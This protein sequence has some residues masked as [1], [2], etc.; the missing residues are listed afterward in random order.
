MF[1][2]ENDEKNGISIENPLLSP[3]ENASDI[4]INSLLSDNQKDELKLIPQSYSDVLSD[5]PGTTSVIEHDVM[6]KSEVPVTKK[7]ICYHMHYVK[8]VK[9]EIDDMLE[10]GIAEK[11]RSTYASSIVIVP[12]MMVQFVY[13]LIIDN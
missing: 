12:K 5:V 1:D 8:K 2:S 11:S 9:M 6:V 13:V 7:Y 10:A 4:Q 3:N